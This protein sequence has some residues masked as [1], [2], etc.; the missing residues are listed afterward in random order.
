MKSGKNK[1]L[2]H[3]ELEDLLV[4]SPCIL[5]SDLDSCFYRKCIAI[6]SFT[7]ST[8]TA[9]LA[10]KYILTSQVKEKKNNFDIEGEVFCLGMFLG[11]LW[12][13]LCAI[14][15]CGYKIKSIVGAKTPHKNIV[16]CRIYSHE[17]SMEF[18]I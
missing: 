6:Y 13:L 15:N 16:R 14:Y 17:R 3:M 9:V 12:T 5:I 7:L 1:K 4:Y 18:I 2:L 11:Y 8:S 10:V